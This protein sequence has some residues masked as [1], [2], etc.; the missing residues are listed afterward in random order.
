MKRQIF[1]LLTFFFLFLF[2]PQFVLAD[3]TPTPTPQPQ[4]Q[5]V[6]EFTVQNQPSVIVGLLKTFITGFDSFLGGFIF[7]TPDPMANPII[8]KDNSQIPGMT[9]YRDMFYQIALPLVAIIVAAFAI[10]RLGSE[11]LYSLKSFFVRLLIV[12]TLFITTP[13][14]LSYSVQFNNLLVSKITTTQTMTSFLNDYFDQT[15]AQINNTNSDQYGIPSFDLSLASGVLNSLG[16]FIVQILLFAITF[17]FL[18]FGLIYIGF[19]F[20]IRFAAILFLGVLYPV[21]IPFALS[22]KTEQIVFTFFRTWFTFLIA[23][24]AF[25]LGFAIATDIFDSLLKAKGPSIGLLFFY[26]GFLFF[27]GGVNVLVGRIF[28]DFWGS[29]ATNMQAAIA[30][31]A[32]TSAITST[33]GVLRGLIS[34]GSGMVSAYKANSGNGSQNGK[35]T[36]GG[37]NGDPNQTGG[38]AKQGYNYYPRSWNQ[39]E[40]GRSAILPG[41][42]SSELSKQG[43]QISMENKNQGIV[44][45]SGTGYA[46]NNPKTGLNTIYTS[47]NDAV[48]DGALQ[49]DIRTVQLNNEQFIDPSLFANDRINP[50]NKV[51]DQEAKKLNK[52]PNISYLSATNSPE[53]VRNFLDLTRERNK[54]LGVSGVMIKRYGSMGGKDRIIRL[55]TDKEL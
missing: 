21:V 8:L 41:S 2:K 28:G 14:V 33:P 36:S 12:I 50:H 4:V 35:D 13:Y 44:S 32:T 29:F 5:F 15:S 24:P 54:S 47:R 51:I 42:F 3:N 27:L 10:G 11:N 30:T 48:Q 26:T 55:Y 49:K 37:N 6:N 18:L 46:Y 22:E 19:Q 7:Y 52:N 40:G 34:K 53:R 38:V 39:G 45:V 23:Q 9:K 25:V 16:K 43:Y 31:R 20:V 1:L 17:L